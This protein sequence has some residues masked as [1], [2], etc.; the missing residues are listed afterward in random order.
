MKFKFIHTNIDLKRR[1]RELRKNA[2]VHE[3]ILWSYLRTSGIGFKF[4]RQHSIGPYIVDFYCAEKRLIIEVDG[5][6]HLELEAKKYD[7]E[8]SKYLQNLHHRVIRFLNSDI[9]NNVESVLDEIRYILSTI[10]SRRLDSLPKL[11]RESDL[12]CLI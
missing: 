10:P 9:N 12:P 6:Q 8:R 3:K 2:T 5:G 4:R 11:G 7:E 1:R